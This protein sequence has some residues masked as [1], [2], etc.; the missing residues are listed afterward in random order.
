MKEQ[1]TI[2][3]AALV[4][5][6]FKIVAH[7]YLR[8]VRLSAC[9]R[10]RG[11]YALHVAFNSRLC[12]ELPG[13]Y[14][15]EDAAAF[16][17]RHRRYIINR[18]RRTPAVPD[19]AAGE[20]IWLFG[21]EYT[22][23]RENDGYFLN[24]NER[25]VCGNS[26]KDYIRGVLLANGQSFLEQ[27]TRAA[28]KRCGVSYRAVRISRGKSYWA[29][30][31]RKEGGCVIC[32]RIFACL[33][34]ERLLNYLAVHELCHVGRFHHGADFWAAVEK[35]VPDYKACHREL[36]DYVAEDFNERLGVDF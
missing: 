29:C 1:T 15:E 33:L 25:I 5:R 28:A 32:Y 9:K 30:C 27:Y 24:G 12:L 36:G 6:C 16:V 26:V 31:R 34:P 23:T 10:K 18:L 7:P 35:F 17:T 11:R 2:E 19:Y 13:G 22:V 14:Q 20:R 21:N 4:A 8:E 3:N